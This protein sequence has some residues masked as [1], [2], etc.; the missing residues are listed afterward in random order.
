MGDLLGHIECLRSI[1]MLKKISL[2]IGLLFWAVSSHA[3]I[4]VYTDRAAW[5]TAVLAGPFDHFHDQ[6]FENSPTGSLN[7]GDNFFFPLMVTIPGTPG[8]NAIDDSFTTDPFS[9]ALSPN[10]STYYLGDVGV[11]A[12]EAP[13]LS[14]PELEF[15]V[16]GFGADW[17]IQGDLIMEIQGT[18]IPFST[19]LPT[20]SGFLGII[21]DQPE[22]PLTANLLGTAV[23]GM[24]DIRT[25][26]AP[27]PAAVWLFG[28]GL[29]GLIGV[30]RR[31]SHV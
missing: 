31:K 26:N 13:T 3:A 24:D 21:T 30:A 4:V 18:F 29:I 16:T 6:N 9:D 14:F 17:V 28:S 12:S 19:Y 15:V 27:I 22:S 20:G 10:G 5:E 11:D 2:L 23:F 8:L 25:A 7:T 1:K